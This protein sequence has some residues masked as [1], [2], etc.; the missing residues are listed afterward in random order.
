M[1]TSDAIANAISDGLREEFAINSRSVVSYVQHCLESPSPEQWNDDEIIIAILKMA[2]NVHDLPVNHANATSAQLS[3]LQFAI[4]R[5]EK[6]KP[7]DKPS[8]NNAQHTNNHG[9]AVSHQFN[10]KHQN[11]NTGSGYQF[12][13]I[14][15]NWGQFN[16]GN[17][18]HRKQLEENQDVPEIGTAYNRRPRFLFGICR[19]KLGRN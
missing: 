14:V 6:I 12:N 11:N 7:K 13:I 16:S 17:W 5:L 2:K 8:Y 3:G 9:Y 15:G 19:S 1:A 10:A 4:D 18:R